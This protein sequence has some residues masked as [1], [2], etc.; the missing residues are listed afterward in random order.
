V[1]I[2]R[3]LPTPPV[4]PIVG[5]NGNV[6][7]VWLMFVNQLIQFIN[8]RNLFGLA[9]ERPPATSVYAGTVY[10]ETDTGATV[11]STGTA[12]V[13]YSST[14]VSV[15]PAGALDGDGSPGAP[16][17][18]RVDGSSVV[19]NAGNQLEGL[20]RRTTVVLSDADILALPSTS[21]PIVTPPSGYRI[22]P[23]AGTWNLD[24]SNGAYA[25]VDP[26]YAALLI[27]TQS[28]G[29][30]MYG[31]IANDST[32]APTPLTE[33]TDLLGSAWSKVFDMFPPADMIQGAPGPRSWVQNYPPANMPGVADLDG[34]P[35]VVY[36]DNNGAGNLT[37]GGAG[38]TLTVT[39]YWAYEAV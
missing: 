24:S 22:K 17:A 34:V 13:A 15:D 4:A 32:I 31:V 16:L 3:G 28:S 37:G 9:S 23:I 19:V 26:T 6:S 35:L 25:N 33:L 14:V 5:A 21:V 12:W 36:F 20:V 1:A 27:A 11:I 18:V 29:Y 7:Q 8:Q 38:N 30:F 2:I 10:F 39:L